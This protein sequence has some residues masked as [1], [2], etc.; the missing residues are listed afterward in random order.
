[1]KGKE[2][3][4]EA[5]T[6]GGS[7]GQAREAR[8]P[9]P[10]IFCQTEARRSEKSFWETAPTPSPYLRIWMTGAP[11]MTGAVAQLAQQSDLLAQQSD[12]RP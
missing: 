3:F 9:P 4:K 12:P 2:L 11:G 7:R 6:S 8:P 5:L 10:L 1:M